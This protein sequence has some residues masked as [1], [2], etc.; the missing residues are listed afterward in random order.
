MFWWEISSYKLHRAAKWLH[1]NPSASFWCRNK[2]CGLCLLTVNVLGNSVLASSVSQWYPFTLIGTS[3]QSWEQ[4]NSIPTFFMSPMVISSII[5][6][7]CW[8]SLTLHDH[9]LP[10]LHSLFPCVC[11]FTQYH[12][13]IHPE[14]VHFQSS[15]LLCMRKKRH[16]TNQRLDWYQTTS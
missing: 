9:L 11:P 15:L 13:H 1:C 2:S 14:T 3:P 10:H 6:P 12:G 5:T 7:Y 16:V 8:L 4:F